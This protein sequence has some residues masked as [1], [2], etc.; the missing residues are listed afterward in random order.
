MLTPLKWNV[1]RIQYL[2]LFK[3]VTVS[4]PTCFVC[5]MFQNTDKDVIFSEWFLDPDVSPCGLR[6]PRLVLFCFSLESFV[7]FFEKLFS[8]S[9]AIVWTVLSW[10]LLSS[11]LQF[12]F[13]PGLF[14]SPII[15]EENLK[16]M[17]DLLAKHGFHQEKPFED[18]SLRKNQCFTLGI[19]KLSGRI[20]GLEFKQKTRTLQPTW[21]KN[22]KKF[23]EIRFFYR[24]AFFLVH[25]HYG[26]KGSDNG[27]P[28]LYE[29]VK[30]ILLEC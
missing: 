8:S 20:R 1:W 13:H 10:I 15:T 25:Q 9:L 3:N 6:D 24:H 17:K 22:S 21:E 2:S 16:K 18:F 11:F 29:S 4:I 26:N 19:G 23:Q 7:S 30:G 14:Q 12:F 5:S 28:C 27:C